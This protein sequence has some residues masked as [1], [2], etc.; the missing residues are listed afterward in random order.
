MLAI[1]VYLATDTLQ[2]FERLFTF[3]QLYPRL[4]DPGIGVCSCTISELGIGMLV[5]AE[6]TRVYLSCN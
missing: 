4:W 6:H 2:C 1:C 5:F 3:Y